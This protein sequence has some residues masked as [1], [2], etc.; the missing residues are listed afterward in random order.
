MD[1]FSQYKKQSNEAPHSKSRT[2]SHSSVNK[3]LTSIQGLSSS[4]TLSTNNSKQQQQQQQ[5]Q[6]ATKLPS[7]KSPA[8]S[9]LKDALLIGSSSP[10]ISA[11]PLAV[12]NMISKSVNSPKTNTNTS[13]VKPSPAIQSPTN[14]T[15]RSSG[16]N[17]TTT[18]RPSTD[19]SHHRT[20]QQVIQQ[21]KTPSSSSR[22]QSNTPSSASISPAS[23]RPTTGFTP[24][25]EQQV[26]TNCICSLFSKYLIFHL[27]YFYSQIV[28]IH[29]K[30]HH[31]H[32]HY[33]NQ[34][35]GI[36]QHYN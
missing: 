5:Q 7:E 32:L 24:T 19:F 8:G 20:D 21:Q 17:K 34:F 4:Q 25:H 3:D 18:N 12:D 14:N 30:F 31:F 26:N 16:S 9:F 6:F 1:L 10:K 33:H 27:F 35:N 11:S 22:P 23:R 28:V 36:Q 13:S 2:S 15:Q 29:L